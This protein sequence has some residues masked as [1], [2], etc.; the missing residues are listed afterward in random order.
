MIDGGDAVR[1]DR[2]Q[3]D[4]PLLAQPVVRGQFGDGGG[5]SHAGW[6]H[7]CHH[8]A[9][10]RLHLD[11]PTDADVFL[12]HPRDTRLE[13]NGIVQ[14]A[15]GT[16]RAHAV[17]QL[18]CQILADLGV[19]QIREQMKQTLRQLVHGRMLVVP[20]EVFNQ[21][22]QIVKLAFQVLAEFLAIVE[23]V[24]RRHVAVVVGC[25]FL[26][27]GGPRRITP[28][29][30][31]SRCGG[32]RQAAG[33]VDAGRGKHFDFPRS[34]QPTQQSTTDFACLQHSRVGAQCAPYLLQCFLHRTGAKGSYIHD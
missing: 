14:V 3:P 17:D 15:A 26:V 33:Y 6:P 9:L 29:P 7:Q 2:D 8:A 24:D 25:A 30:A 22:V 12:D 31:G 19:D 34:R 20:R 27:V 23:R 16:T 32:F 10:G 11:R 28:V 4:P 5:L 18:A 1:I 13:Q 21:R